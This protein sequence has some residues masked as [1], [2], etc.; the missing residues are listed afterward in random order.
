MPL[1]RRS[2]Q[3]PD[4]CLPVVAPQVAPPEHVDLLGESV[5]EPLRLLMY[6]K[7]SWP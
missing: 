7:Q 3:R 4:N 6:P 2:P 1:C 5:A